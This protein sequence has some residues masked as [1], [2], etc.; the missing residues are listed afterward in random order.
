MSTLLE[1]FFQ[2]A[3]TF[4]ICL[5]LAIYPA[6]MIIAFGRRLM[7]AVPLAAASLSLSAALVAL[8]FRFWS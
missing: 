7:R 6:T 2:Y 3:V 1:H 5:A 4:S 8:G